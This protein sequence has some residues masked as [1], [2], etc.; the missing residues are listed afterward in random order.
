MFYQIFQ[1]ISAEIRPRW[2]VL[3]HPDG[4]TDKHNKAV[5]FYNFPNATKMNVV[6][7]KY[8]NT[9]GRPGGIVA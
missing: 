6:D 8:D 4:R 3:I 7:L 5:T 1:Q 9:Q 2:A